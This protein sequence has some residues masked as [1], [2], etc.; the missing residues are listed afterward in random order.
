[1]PSPA[2]AA[3]RPDPDTRECWSSPPPASWL[4]KWP[5]SCGYWLRPR[6]L[7]VDSFYG[8]VGYG[9]QLKALA[10]GVDVAVACPGRLGDLIERGSLF[11]DAVEIVVLDEADRMADMGFLPMFAG[12]S[13]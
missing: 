2:S 10:R 8:G 5:T 4:P 1:M 13:T 12:C 7:R 11:L 9:P 3:G 6:Q